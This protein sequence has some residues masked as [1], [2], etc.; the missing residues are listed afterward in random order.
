M[1]TTTGPAAYEIF[2]MVALDHFKDTKDVL[3]IGCFKDKESDFAKEFVNAAAGIEDVKILIS[4]SD[5][6]IKNI[7]A[8]DNAIILLK[9]FGDARLE[10]DGKPDAHV[11]LPQ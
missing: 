6:V 1:D 11:K 4:S 3:V 9:K 10:Y 7:Q 2:D 5:D 8:K